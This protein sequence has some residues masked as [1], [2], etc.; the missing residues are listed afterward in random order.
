MEAKNLF[1]TKMCLG[2]RNNYDIPPHAAGAYTYATKL[3]QT[4]LFIREN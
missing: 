3:S 4:T 1:N 2:Y